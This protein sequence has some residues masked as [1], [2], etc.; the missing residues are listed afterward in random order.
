MIYMASTDAGKYQGE[1]VAGSLDGG[2][3][4]TFFS[5][6]SSSRESPHITF[7]VFV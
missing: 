1:F 5:S 7:L 6:D 3:S 2:E 4:R